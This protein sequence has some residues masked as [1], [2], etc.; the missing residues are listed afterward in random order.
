MVLSNKRPKQKKK[1]LGFLKNHVKHIM[2]FKS[3]N[4]KT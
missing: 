4:E 3:Y 2:Q 1:L